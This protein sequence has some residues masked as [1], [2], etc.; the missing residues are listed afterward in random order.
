MTYAK[1]PESTPNRYRDRASHE[2]LPIHT[3]INTTPILHLSFTDPSTSFPAT[4]PM[5]GV[6]ASYDRPSAGLD[7]PLDLYL[8]GYISSRVMN[9][10][11]SASTSPAGQAGGDKEGE[12][13]EKGLP[14]TISAA[15]LDGLVLSLTP[16]S[17]SM[18]YRS[19]VLFGHALPV[20]DT[21]EKLWAMEQVT[22]NVVPGRYQNTRV[23]PNGAEMQSTQILKVKVQSGTYKERRGEPHDERC[24]TE[25]DEVTRGVWTGVVPTWMKYGEPVRCGE[26]GV[27]EVPEHVGAFVREMNEEGERT[28]MEAI[29]EPV[30]KK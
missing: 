19:C 15:A 28:A 24:D 12:R 1:G 27:K 4:L 18:N 26:G 10:S 11:R 30:G 7:E 13:G 21:A 22:N 14:V 20:V 6:M 5:I 23:P 3:L 16:N 9:L 17:H 29:K 2:L 25:S 8:H